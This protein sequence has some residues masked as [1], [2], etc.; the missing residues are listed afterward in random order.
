MQFNQQSGVSSPMDLIPR[1][2]LCWAMVSFRGMKS[3]QSTSGAYGDIELTI[4]DGQ[5]FARKKLWE[6]VCDPDDQRNS[7]KWREMGMVSLTRMV[8][9]AGVVD[10]KNPASYEALNGKS[11]QQVLMMLDGKYV[12]IKVKIEDGEDGYA[13]KNKVGDYLTPNEQSQTNKN[14]VKL[15]NG[16]HGITANPANR[17]AGA[18]NAF[19]NAPSAGV[20]QATRPVQGFGTHGAQHAQQQPQAVQHASAMPANTGFN[21]NQAPSFLKAGNG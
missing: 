19:G 15:T 14:F 10:P 21:P 11:C 16:D 5:P 13:D 4:A 1:G 18:G 12:A 2:F 6:M 9:A 3:S 7:E 17:A 8:E 20:P